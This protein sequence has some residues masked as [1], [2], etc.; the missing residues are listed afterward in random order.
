MA[1]H[2]Q[3]LAVTVLDMTGLSQKGGAVMSHVRIARQLRQ[4]HA[5]RIDA[6][7]ADALIGC[8]MAVC[9]SADVLS[10]LRRGRTRAIVN[11]APV[12]GGE[13][14]R[15]GVQAS[16]AEP[17]RQS[18][19]HAVGDA[20]AVFLDATHLATRLLG[21]SI[22]ANMLL[23]GFAWQRGCVPVSRQALARAIE[24]NAVSVAANLA[25]FDWGRRAACDPQG[26]ARMAEQGHTQPADHRLSR[27]L[28]EVIERRSA[29][30]VE[31]Q[32]VRLARRY[33][34]LVGRVREAEER[35]E[36]GSTRLVE[37]VARNA[38]RLLACKDEYEVARLYTDG[39][40]AQAL[41]DTF[42]GDYRLRLHFARPWFNRPD[43]VTG[44]PAKQAYPGWT[45]HGLR[46]LARLKLLRATPFDIFGYS[47][48][49][50]LE[51]ALWTEYAKTVDTLIERL[52]AGSLELACQIAA[53]PDR[54][55]GFGPVKLRHAEL[56]RVRLA[57][58]MSAWP[59]LGQ[60]TV[61]SSALTRRKPAL[62]A[63]T[64]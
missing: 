56:A 16:N 42:E 33:A 12:I 62:Q 19:G 20:A 25:A 48:E 44:E 60:H 52:D 57:E 43:P 2:L 50:R 30:L 5:V 34:E 7:Q 24:L 22:Y 15:R 9:V 4:L 40:F 53:V 64:A 38:F 10:K 27:G 46:L 63:P 35:V 13:F 51:R 55:R 28:D 36:P 8:E 6:G 39:M 32:N 1:A 17:I 49:R 58:L 54:I 18:L 37:A 61:D 26:I 21:H 31:Y 11:T 47:A 23:L 3:G 41:R 45:L 29:Y 59:K 14:V